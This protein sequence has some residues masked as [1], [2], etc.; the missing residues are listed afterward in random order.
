MFIEALKDDIQQVR[1]NELSG[2]YVHQRLIRAPV[3]G[4]RLVDVLTF[5]VPI[6]YFAP[7]LIWTEPPQLEV[8]NIVDVILSVCLLAAAVLRKV[9]HWDEAIQGHRS[10][11][12][13]NTRTAN[14]AQELLSDEHATD[15]AAKWFL[16]LAKEPDPEEDR[17]LENVCD[18]LMHQAYRSALKEFAPSSA[19]ARCQVCGSS[20]WHHKS[21]PCQACGG[22]PAQ[23]EGG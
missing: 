17:L 1:L 19:E 6:L 20:I 23:E 21:G 22:T 10:A 16:R 12:S 18:K 15:D 14:Q 3:R 2:K 8:I 9:L 13:K 5:G 4:A 11:I 7:K